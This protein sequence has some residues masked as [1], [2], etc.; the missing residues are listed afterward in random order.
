MEKRRRSRSTCSGSGRARS[1]SRDLRRKS[2]SLCP[3]SESGWQVAK[4]GFGCRRPDLASHARRDYGGG[5]P[6][7]PWSQSS[8]S[9]P[10]PCLPKRLRTTGDRREVSPRATWQVAPGRDSERGLDDK[11]PRSCEASGGRRVRASS[12]AR[13]PP[14]RGRQERGREEEAKGKQLLREQRQEEEEK[15]AEEGKEEAAPRFRGVS[16]R[17]Q[18]E[19]F[20]KEVGWEAS[21]CSRAEVAASPVLRNRPGPKRKN[22]DQG[23][24][25]G[26]EVCR[27]EE[28]QDKFI[29]KFIRKLDKQ[30]RGGHRSGEFVP[31]GE[32][33]QSGVRK[34]P[35]HSQLRDLADDAAKPTYSPGR[36]Q[37]RSFCSTSGNPV[38]QAGDLEEGRRSSGEGD[39]DPCYFHRPLGERQASC[40]LRRPVPEAE[41]LREHGSG[42]SLADRPEDGNPT[43]RDFQHRS[44]R[45]TA[46]GS[47][48]ELPG[49]QDKLLGKGTLTGQRARER[50]QVR[51]EGRLQ[52]RSRTSQRKSKGRRQGG[53]RQEKGQVVSGDYD[54]SPLEDAGVTPEDGWIVGGDYD[55]SPLEDA[56]VTPVSIVVE[57][58]KLDKLPHDV[59]IGAEER[60]GKEQIVG[61]TGNVEILSH[62]GP[63]N[64]PEKG[65]D[66]IVMDGVT[67]FGP[68]D[69]AGTSRLSEE[70]DACLDGLAWG[71]CTLGSSG[72]V[73][74][75]HLLEVFISLRSKTTGGR[76][77]LSVFPLPTSRSVLV[78]AFPELSGDGI[79]WLLLI[80]IGLNS[81]WGS[82]IFY[83]GNI[84]GAQRSCL[85]ALCPDVSRICSIEGNVEIFDWSS[86]FGSRTV[87]YQ[88]DEVKVAHSFCWENIAP[89]LPK[90]IGSVPLAEICTLGCKYYVENFDL[91]VKPKDQW[92]KIKPPRVMV[93]DADWG[94]VCTGLV[95]SGVCRFLPREDLFEGPEGPLLNGLFGVTKDEICGGFEV[96]R[97]IMNLIPLNSICESLSG[98]VNSL[99]GWSLM[100]PFFMQPSEELLISSE[101]VRCFFYVMRV[102]D[103]WVKYLGFKKQ[104]P[105]CVLPESLRGR[106]TYLAAC[107]LPMG[108]LNSVSL[109]QHVHRNLVLQSPDVD[110]IRPEEELRKDRC[111]S[112]SQ[113]NWRVYLDN[114]DL[115]EKV[116][117]TQVV[118][119]KGTTPPA[120]L[121]LREQYASWEV[122]RNL[123]KSVCRDVRAE[124]QGAQVDGT[125]GVAYPREQKLLKYFSAGL[126]ICKLELVSQRQMQVVCGGLVY[127]TMF[128]R[129]LLGCLN[130]VWKF[131]ES[132]NSSTRHR[133]PLPH[134]CKLEILRFLALI[135]LAR[136]DFRLDVDS[137]VTC[138]DASSSGGGICASSGLTPMGV[139]A[140]Q[141]YLHGE[142][143]E[144]R[145]GIKVLSVGLFDGIG[146]LRVALDL[147]EVDVIGHISVEVDQHASRVVESQFPETEKVDDVASVD[148][149]MVHRWSGRYSQASLILIGAGP[150]CQ[151]VSGLNADRK[152]ALKD[153]RSKLFVHVKR[154]EGH[155]KCCF[156]WSPVHTLMES[157]ASMDEEDRS[158]MSEHFEDEPW[159]C[160]AKFML[161]CCRPRLYWITWEIREGEGVEMDLRSNPPELK[162]SAQQPI[163]DI[164]KEGWMKADPLTSF[165]TFTTSRP[166][167]SAG[168]KPAGVKQCTLVELER[169]ANDWYRFPPY[170]YRNC[171]CLIN[172]SGEFRLP[173]IE[174]REIIMG[175]PVN[176]TA[177]C[178]SK[179]RR[180]SQEWR[181]C[182]LT[183]LGNSWAVPV[184]AWL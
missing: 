137:Q 117:A 77:S 51:S 115:L 176:Y 30:P 35:R 164:C 68:Q 31:G 70:K 127:V 46:T 84:S 11:P 33:S 105:D 168:H 182:R 48:G 118:D 167:R 122:P 4:S 20:G 25:K 26:Q 149:D 36:R 72:N 143:P 59:A 142:R 27:Q 109:A 180:G 156:P 160:D 10:D 95:E 63:L 130:Q 24:G 162:L 5:S 54:G 66:D 152:G 60:L 91:F 138:S 17:G 159:K 126:G 8:C 56:R 43:T 171:H 50:R 150:P 32:Q 38:L 146:A 29:G 44:S 173:S 69:P 101:D 123:K 175:F 78:D 15:E 16:R 112:L 85:K 34:V 140:S 87:D 139:L 157:V 147:L 113:R 37:S 40:S 96:Y 148:F 53:T 131:I 73:L 120:L 108:F 104:V 47:E 1:G 2:F 172:R 183:L 52:G 57:G 128:R 23:P 151:G 64:E 134:G 133:L 178:M 163:E 111:F 21:T 154:I 125:L 170:Q 6:E 121:A 161:W 55:G 14:R 100:N 102:P 169:W 93:H 71:G 145:S 89:A 103:C 9:L 129:P 99:P 132:F 166:R 67:F 45:R 174:E 179:S 90:E 41:V 158:T 124:V 58:G 49:C 98:D 106:E 81:T 141:G 88:G 92:P 181:D 61:L 83:D 135:P 184:V 119:L 3:R 12:G 76:N 79:T 74:L 165:P 42:H 62:P 153:H 144:S 155:F 177:G 114:F 22:K 97:L 7:V 86:F 82:E 13:S 107:V 19:G 75:Q 94:A 39:V 116:E 65:L 18:E 110:S 136:L 80:C 28:G